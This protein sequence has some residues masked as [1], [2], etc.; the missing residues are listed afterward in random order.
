MDYKKGAK[1]ADDLMREGDKTTGAVA[2]GL[3][4]KAL[5]EYSKA[6]EKKGVEFARQKIQEQLQDKET[7]SDYRPDIKSLRRHLEKGRTSVSHGDIQKEYLK[8]IGWKATLESAR[9]KFTG[10]YNSKTENRYT[11]GGMEA[12][13]LFPRLVA[14]YIEKTRA[15]QTKKDLF[16]FVRDEADSLYKKVVSEREKSKKLLSPAQ[17]ALDCRY[18]PGNSRELAAIARKSG[19]D[20]VVRGRE[21]TKVTSKS[22]R[23]ITTIPRNPT[24][25]TAENIVNALASGNPTR[26]ADSRKPGKK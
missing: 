25:Y 9:E 26:L 2:I 20:T 14:K 18:F 12:D 5:K 1:N 8:K 23:I 21:G 15:G 22:G 17:K 3:Y 24:R 10:W 13:V 6:G 19:Y 7:K 16:S 4:Q 11:A